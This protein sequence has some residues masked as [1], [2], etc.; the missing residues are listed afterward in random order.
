LTDIPPSEEAVLPDLV[1]WCIP[2][3]SGNEACY[4]HAAVGCAQLERARHLIT[5]KRRIYARYSSELAE[6]AGIQF[7]RE[8]PWATATRW[9]STIAI[10][11]QVTGITAG[12]LRAR[13]AG[14]GVQT[15]PPWTPLHLTGAHRGC[16]PWPC[17]VAERFGRDALHLP[18]SVTLTGDQQNRVLAAVR[19]AIGQP[20]RA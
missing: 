11:P 8:A 16:A 1:P 12:E 20:A 9:L 19:A 17:P 2:D 5:A 14:D 18:N 13:L 7:Q 15:G 10:E 4:L 3:L 6:L